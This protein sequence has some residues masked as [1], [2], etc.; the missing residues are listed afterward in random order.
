MARNRV[1][2][3]HD[4]FVAGAQASLVRLEKPGRPQPHNRRCGGWI[5]IAYNSFRAKPP[6]IHGRGSPLI[7]SSKASGFGHTYFGFA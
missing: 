6:L 2:Q 3:N 4:L 5:F 1:S 7:A